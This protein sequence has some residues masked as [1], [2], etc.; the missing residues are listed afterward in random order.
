[1]WKS[2]LV[3]Q[4]ARLPQENNTN[5]VVY[6]T[7]NFCPTFLEARVQDQGMARFISSEGCEGEPFH[8]YLLVSGDL[9]AVF[10]VAWLLLHHHNPAFFFIWCSVCMPVHVQMAPFYKKSDVLNLGPTLPQYCFNFTNYICN[11]LTYK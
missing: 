7:Y 11:D 4:F 9:L 2:Y 8:A 5:W 6:T 3:Y 1:M 10:G